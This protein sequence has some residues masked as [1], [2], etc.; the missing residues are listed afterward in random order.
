[1]CLLNGKNEEQGKIMTKYWIRV[2]SDSSYLIRALFPVRKPRG[3]LST[4]GSM[5]IN[6]DN[7][8]ES[9]YYP[10]ETQDMFAL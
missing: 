10:V 1:M 8:R 7:L 6:N 2:G 3:T 9:V 5:R 4:A